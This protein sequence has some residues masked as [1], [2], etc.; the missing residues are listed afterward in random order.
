MKKV[1]FDGKI[2]NFFRGKGFMLVLLLSVGAIGT[3]TYIA[4]NQTMDRLYG[5]TPF[6]TSNAWVYPDDDIAVNV[7]KDGV[8]KSTTALEVISPDDAEQANKPVISTEP[9][10]M[11]VSGEIIQDYSNGELVKSST[12]GV[13]KTHDGIDIAAD[14]GTQVKAMTKGVVQEVKED[15]LWG[16]VVVILHHNGLTGYYCNLE[17]VIPVKTGQEVSG[18]DVIGTVGQSAEIE[19]ADAPHLHFGLKDSGKWID[20]K[21]VIETTE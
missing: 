15:P 11:P 14:V 3:A 19:I 17:P 20:P 12:L 13:W 9:N 21:S 18:G 6:S 2:G 5:N 7:N 16:Y 10:M 8:P 4:Y 1:K